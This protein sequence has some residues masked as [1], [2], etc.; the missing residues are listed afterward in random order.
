MRIIVR[1]FAR[2][3][4]RPAAGSPIHVQARDT[5]YEDGPAPV[6]A[7][8]EGCV[9]GSGEEQP[10]EGEEPSGVDGS[11]AQGALDV[12]ELTV[13]SLPDSARVWAHVDVDGDGRLSKGDFVTMFAY[14]IPATDVAEMDVEVRRI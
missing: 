11:K 4:D 3:D 14:P 6:I 10:E 13:D 9:R 2:D 8:A 1:L 12:V 5:T 7:S